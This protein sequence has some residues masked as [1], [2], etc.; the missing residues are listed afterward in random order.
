[1]SNRPEE[2]RDRT[3]KFGLR[4]LKLFQSLP[5]RTD[6]QVLG[7]QLL[8]S[9]TSVGANYRAAGRSRSRAEFSARIAVVSEEA[10]E[11]VFWLELLSDGGIVPNERLRDLLREANEL[12]AIF[13]AAHETAR[14][15]KAA[16]PTMTRGKAFTSPDGPI[17][18]S[19][20][21]PQMPNT[22]ET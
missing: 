3:K 21:S 22:R 19:P 2:L 10:D 8:R 16:M 20:D 15:A 14:H 13:G 12:A 18:R 4:I 7:K 17:T 5:K 11:T 6:A 9:G 1:L